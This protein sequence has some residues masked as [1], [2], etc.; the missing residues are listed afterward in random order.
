MSDMKSMSDKEILQKLMEK[1][2]WT[3]TNLAERLGF[4]RSRVS[5]VIHD[6]QSLR[7]AVR[8]LAEMLYSEFF[9]VE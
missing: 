2:N 6:H 4:D 8:R 1:N 3:Q 9:L 5:K 7:P